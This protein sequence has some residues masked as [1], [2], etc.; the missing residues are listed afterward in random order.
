MAVID[1]K[2][3]LKKGVT[4]LID[5]AIGAALGALA[6][7]FGKSKTKRQIESMQAT[8]DE[9]MLREQKQSGTVKILLFVFAGLALILVFVLVIRKKR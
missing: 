7:L 9:L 2:P 4:G 8:A 1:L 6:G 3:S 5:T